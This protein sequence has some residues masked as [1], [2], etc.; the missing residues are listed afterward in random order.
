VFAKDAAGNTSNAIIYFQVLEEPHYITSLGVVQWD[1]RVEG[2][3]AGVDASILLYGP[4]IPD[5]RVVSL[6]TY[7]PTVPV[8]VV[9]P[10]YF[11]LFIIDEEGN[12][13]NTK[14]IL[15]LEIRECDVP[16]PASPCRSVYYDPTNDIVALHFRVKPSE[17]VLRKGVPSQI[18][19]VGWA[20]VRT[21]GLTF[22]GSASP[23]ADSSLQDT[24]TNLIRLGNCTACT[25]PTRQPELQ[26][27]QLQVCECKW[28][29]YPARLS[30][31]DVDG[32]TRSRGCAI[33]PG[34]T[35]SRRGSGGPNN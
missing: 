29:A 21:G 9:Q 31:N 23:S 20:A 24:L 5:K 17:G 14:P 22:E 7:P 27:R 25:K 30:P 13:L 10:L 15:P 16:P 34:Y 26:R 2:D 4:L 32:D 3:T 33:S 35:D 12:V 28:V 11:A 8:C 1:W 6:G 19:I 18:K